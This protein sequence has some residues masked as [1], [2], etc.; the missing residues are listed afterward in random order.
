M[1]LVEEV[2]A[3]ELRDKTW[4]C[5]KFWEVID[6]QNLFGKLDTY[7]E[8]IFPDGANIEEVNDVLRHEGED[9]LNALGADLTDTIWDKDKED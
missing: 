5:D 6:N 9:V 3:D 8:T 2:Y 7:L 1:K 4:D